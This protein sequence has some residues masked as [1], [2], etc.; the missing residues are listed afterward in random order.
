MHMLDR[1]SVV[2]ITPFRKGVAGFDRDALISLSARLGP[3]KLFNEKE[4]PYDVVVTVRPLR[5]LGGL[6][7]WRIDCNPNRCLRGTESYTWQDLQDF[8]ALFWDPADVHAMQGRIRLSTWGKGRQADW[9]NTGAE[10]ELAALAELRVTRY[11]LCSDL[12][13]DVAEIS[14]RITRGSPR[15]LARY[16]EWV[17]GRL[18][19]NGSYAGKAPCVKTYNKMPGPMG[20]EDDVVRVEFQDRPKFMLF[21][22]VAQFFAPGFCFA[23]HCGLRVGSY[24]YAASSSWDR[25]CFEAAVEVHGMSIVRGAMGKRR[26]KRLGMD[27]IPALTASLEAGYLTSVYS[28]AALGEDKALEE[29]QGYQDKE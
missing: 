17:R 15:K 12:Q 7:S 2:S 8:I 18:T 29:W 26:R 9:L 19:L 3:I 25:L 22:D 20:R 11:D 10:T 16:Y 23:E 4:F 27:D 1:L 14:R 28:W 5:T 21:G 13:G 6:W 24:H